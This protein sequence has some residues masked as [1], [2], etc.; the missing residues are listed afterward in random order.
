MELLND[1]ITGSTL[2]AA[3]WNQVPSELQNIITATGQSLSG[4]D[5]DQ[6]G[7]GIAAYVSNSDFYVSSGLA[8][9]YILTPLAG[10]QAPVAYF[11][12][13]RVR[14]IPNINNTGGSVTLML[15]D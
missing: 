14:F 6:V 1:K 8:D 3:E 13:M 15:M 11:D 5:L 9:D 4:G 10:V 7:K 12:G 2:T